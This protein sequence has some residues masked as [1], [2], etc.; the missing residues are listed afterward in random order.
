VACAAA[1]ATLDL[2]ESELV[3][4]AAKVGARV[5]EMLRD[6]V[7][8]HPAVGDIRGRG[9]MIGVELVKDRGTKERASDL[10]N[11]VVMHAFL[12][13]GMV[14]LGAGQNTIRFCP[15]LTL[16]EEEAAVAVDIFATTLNEL[17]GVRNAQV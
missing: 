6:A 10:R 8:N 14:I 9:L 1:V 2:L 17:T 7:G 4:N 5:M 13:H 12:K 16:S 11:D 3:D 15:G